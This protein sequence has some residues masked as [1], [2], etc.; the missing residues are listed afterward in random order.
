MPKEIYGERYEFLPK[1][2]LLTFEEITRLARLEPAN[3]VKKH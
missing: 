3:V 2:E 1:A